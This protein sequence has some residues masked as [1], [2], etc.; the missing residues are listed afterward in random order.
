MAYYE[1][2]WDMFTR[3]GSM[4]K[5]EDPNCKFSAL[6]KFSMGDVLKSY[7]LCTQARSGDVT[8]E[9]PGIFDIIA[10]KE[11]DAWAEYRG[12]SKEKAQRM[13][14]NFITLLIEKEGFTT[15]DP[16]KDSKEQEYKDC[17]VG[18]GMDEKD[19]EN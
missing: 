9:R 1:S 8:G 13:C 18:E 15:E 14:I 6:R 2:L 7:A 17:L 16:L 12:V 19:I 3:I 5:P 4:I 10:R 11:W